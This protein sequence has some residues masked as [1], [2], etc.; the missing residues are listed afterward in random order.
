MARQKKT[1]KA[2]KA[3]LPK[4]SFA[5]IAKELALAYGRI[6]GAPAR[7]L[8]WLLNFSELNLDSLSEGRLADLRWELVVFA[9]NR[10]PAEMKSRF[11]IYYE[12][13]LLTLPVPVLKDMPLSE[14]EKASPKA[15]TE[16]E[17]KKSLEARESEERKGASLWLV[18][19][20]QTTMRE[21]FT[22]LFSG[23]PWQFTRPARNEAVALTHIKP[24]SGAPWA[25]NP[26]AYTAEDILLMQVIDLIKAEWLRLRRCQNP[27]CNR[28]PRFVAANKDRAQFCSPQCSA[29][30]RV[31]K[32]RG[33]L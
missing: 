3:T 17:Y 32:K 33:K 15:E 22:T 4:D 25:H 29:Y 21:I 16:E 26:P 18:K 1:P 8:R 24:A 9:L 6:N 7:R 27:Q 10:K 12:L 13:S 30:V 31:S 11:G 2:K 19:E 28:H 23:E 14:I 5:P 20:F